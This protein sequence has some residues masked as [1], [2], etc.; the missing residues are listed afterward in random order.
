[1]KS[2][3]GFVASRNPAQLEKSLQALQVVAKE[4][5]PEGTLA[6][7]VAWDGNRALD[8]PSDAGAK[9]YLGQLADVV[10]DVLDSTTR[11]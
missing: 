7:L 5:Y 1:V 10:R 8:D 4:H 11:Q 2:E 3:L 9:A 6:R